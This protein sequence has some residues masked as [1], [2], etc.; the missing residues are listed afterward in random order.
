VTCARNWRLV[1]TRDNV[2]LRFYATRLRSACYAASS[3]RGGGVPESEIFVL[4]CQPD[5]GKAAVPQNQPEDA[6]THVSASEEVGLFAGVGPALLGAVGPFLAADITNGFGSGE[7]VAAKGDAF[8]LP[9]RFGL[10][11]ETAQKCKDRLATGGI[12][13][14]VQ[15]NRDSGPAI[16]KIFEEAQCWDIAEA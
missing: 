11:T 9:D 4:G 15:L 12:L 1:P 2:N 14:V 8:K 6:E 7:T 3:W 13:I 5:E 10:S 16:R